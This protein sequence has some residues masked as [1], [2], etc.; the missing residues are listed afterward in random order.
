MSKVFKI[1]VMVVALL[2]LLTEAFN[3]AP[4]KTNQAMRPDDVREFGLLKK[5]PAFG[6]KSDEQDHDTVVVEPS[7]FALS[8]NT[9]TH[10]PNFEYGNE[11]DM[12]VGK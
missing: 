1:V 2:V 3:C 11:D 7:D 10:D 8:N 6:V 12:F 4:T 9:E 5:S